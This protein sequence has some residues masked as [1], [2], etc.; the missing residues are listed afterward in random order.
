MCEA[1]VCVKYN[2]QPSTIWST[3]MCLQVQR[4]FV[5]KS[6]DSRLS[7]LTETWSTNSLDKFSILVIRA[8]EPDHHVNLFILSLLSSTYLGHLFE[9][10]HPTTAPRGFVGLNRTRSESISAQHAQLGTGT[11]NC[12]R[13][14]CYKVRLVVAMGVVLTWK[15][16]QRSASIHDDCHSFTL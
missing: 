3:L 1:S 15:A 13:S 12:S 5:H 10:T 16:V 8:I 2:L 14:R 7:Q 6:Q 4:Y 9:Y 11:S